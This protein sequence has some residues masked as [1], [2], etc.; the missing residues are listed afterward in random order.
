[1]HRSIMDSAMWES[2]P[3]SRSQAWIDMLM[4]ANHKPGVIFRRGVKVEIPRGGIGKS[5]RTLAERWS[6]SHG[7]VERF[8]SFLL[9][10]E[11]VK[12]VGTKK[13]SVDTCYFIVNYEKYQECGDENR[14]EDGK[15]TGRR[16]EEDGDGTRMEEGK[17]GRKEINNLPDSANRVEVVEVEGEVFYLSKK[18][19]KLKGVV[20]ESFNRFWKAFAY[21]HGKAE[22]AD[23]WLSVYSPGMV[24]AAV[25]AAMSEAQGRAD[26]LANGKSPKWAQ[27][28]LTGRRWE[29]GDCSNSS[30]SGS[31]PECRHRNAPACVEKDDSRRLNCKYF[32]AER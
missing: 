18:K 16:R 21:S 10:E 11:M 30:D 15:K 25:K 13:T 17:K 29:D 6:W 5:I 8:F 12:K 4:L 9:D 23:A 1:M 2:E 28:W 20:L 31:C 7:K 24:D 32:E 26:I 19:K 3:F 14:A 22:A 27:G